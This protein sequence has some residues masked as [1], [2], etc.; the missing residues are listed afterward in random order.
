[1]W[2]MVVLGVGLMASSLAP[3]NQRRLVRVGL[4]AGATLVVTVL[5]LH[6]ATAAGWIVPALPWHTQLWVWSVLFALGWFSV[7][8]RSGTRRSRV[9]GGFAIPASLLMALALFNAYFYYIPTLGELFGQRAADQMNTAQVHQF[10]EA[11]RF[12]TGMKVRNVHYRSMRKQPFAGVQHGRFV[13]EYV[14]RQERR[15]KLF[16]LHMRTAPH[17]IVLPVHLGA[18]VSRFHAMHG[19]VYLPPAWWGPQRAQLPVVEL[20]GGTPSTPLEWLRG[21]QVQTSADA[22]ASAHQGKAPILV[23]VDDNGSFAGDTECVDR[24][25]ELAETYALV[26]VRHDMER[27]FHTTTNPKRWGIAGLSEGGMCALAIGLRHPTRFGVIG[28]FGGEPKQS[29]DSPRQT[30]S[31]LFGGSLARQ[32]AYDPDLLVQKNP[33][34]HLS[35]MFIVGSQDGGRRSIVRQADAA[36]RS[37]IATRLR[38]VP[39]GHTYRVWGLAAH[40][41]IPFAWDALTRHTQ[42]A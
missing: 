18:K 13:P 32:R 39:G 30:L 19:L 35:A 4:V 37:G 25:G 5:A 2:P 10:N 17:G 26:D 12:S 6:W 41:F 9:L 11:V 20:L 14:T 33:R 21:A 31:V 36:H 27:R 7:G 29:L 15:Q 24:P 42:R 38:V 22:F 16:A 34:T 8:W 28:D 1:M 40:Q 23:M 3:F